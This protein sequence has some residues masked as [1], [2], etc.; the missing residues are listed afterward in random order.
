[1]IRGAALIALFCLPA[2]GADRTIA[3]FV[4][5]AWVAKDGAP[6]NINA[7]AQTTDGYLW[8]ASNQGL[9]PI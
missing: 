9:L 4:H 6:A 1:M 2:C 3:Q 5:K 7:I 8:L